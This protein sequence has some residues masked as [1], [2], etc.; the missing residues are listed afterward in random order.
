MTSANY[1]GIGCSKTGTTPRPFEGRIAQFG[2]WQDFLPETAIT[3]MFNGGDLAD[4]S[5]ISGSNRMF[6]HD[7]ESISGSTVS[8]QNSG[9]SAHNLVL[10]NGASTNTDLPY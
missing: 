8:T 9:D 2:A 1:P 7:F 10:I 5:Q 3:N 6:V 4:W